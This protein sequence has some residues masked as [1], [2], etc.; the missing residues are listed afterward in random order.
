MPAPAITTPRRENQ[1]EPIVHSSLVEDPIQWDIMEE[2]RREQQKNPPPPVCPLEKHYVPMK[3]HERIITWVHSSLSSGHL[4]CRC[5]LELFR[6]AFWWPECK[7]DVEKL[8]KWC[9]ICA[10][11]KT[12]CQLPEGFLDRVCTELNLNHSSMGPT[13]FQCVLCYQ[14]PMFP[15]LGEPS[16]VPT[17]EDWMSCSSKV[18]ESAHVWIQR[19][20]RSQRIQADRQRRPYPDYRPGQKVWLSTR[21]L[22]LHL[23][24]KKL[25]PKYIGPFCIIKQIHP[26]TYRLERPH[27][28]A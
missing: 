11:S 9:R 4:G 28:T 26:V 24:S 18:W 17:V 22:K 5:T 7:Q 1:P 14:P 10:Q 25:S 12:P 23:P 27:H 8:V 3:L 16:T 2:I 15:W 13:P 6:N 20:V 19:A 21:D